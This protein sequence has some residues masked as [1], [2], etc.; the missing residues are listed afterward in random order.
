MN[1]IIMKSNIILIDSQNPS[2]DSVKKTAENLKS[3]EL[4]VAPTETRYGLLGR[5]D[6]PSALDKLY[7][8]KNRPKSMPTA[9]FVKSINEILRY[10]KTTQISN[11]I[12]ST[13]LPGPLTLVM[14]ANCELPSPIVVDNKIG[15]RYSSS[16]FIEKLLNEIDFPVTATSANLYQAG[17]SSNISETVSVFG[18]RISLYVDAGELSETVSTVVDITSGNPIILRKGAISEKDIFNL[19]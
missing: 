15:I 19:L 8:V 6:S 13:F 5:A 7:K 10:A 3:G 11:K 16:P 14:E 1:N 4:V 9:L 2:D 18:D 12:I 17:E